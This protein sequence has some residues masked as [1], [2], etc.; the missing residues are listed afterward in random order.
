MKDLFDYTDEKTIP[1]TFKSTLFYGFYIFC[2]LFPVY[3]NYFVF[4]YYVRNSF[5]SQNIKRSRL[6]SDD[7][8]IKISEVK[9]RKGIKS[10]LG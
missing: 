1:I 9:A 6:L 2:L 3:V 8:I 10:F 7:D 5:K 4:Y